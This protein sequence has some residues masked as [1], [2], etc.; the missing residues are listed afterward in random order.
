VRR[1][2]FAAL[3]WVCL[4]A[5]GCQEARRSLSSPVLRPRHVTGRGGRLA[6]AP[7]PDPRAA[8]SR[9]NWAND[10]GARCCLNERLRQPAN[11]NAAPVDDSRCHVPRG[12]RVSA[13]GLRRDPAVASPSSVSG[14]SSSCSSISSLRGPKTPRMEAQT[15]TSPTTSPELVGLTLRLNAW[16]R[17]VERQICF[18]NLAAT[19]LSCCRTSLSLVL[20]HRTVVCDLR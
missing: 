20:D 18:D 8:A 12:R 17:S 11:A 16:A 9:H 7:V 6:A 19:R 5:Y 15:S 1:P 3:V 2:G 4:P 10:P 14:S 13:R